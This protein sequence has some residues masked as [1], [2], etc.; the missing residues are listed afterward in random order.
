[1]T[2][3][4]IC[5]KPMELDGVD[6]NCTGNQDEY[7]ACEECD[8][9]ALAKIRYGKIYKT[10]YTDQYGNEIKGEQNK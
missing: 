1:M 3:C 4:P 2:K 6:Y 8:T 9:F 7:Y 10:E 5:G